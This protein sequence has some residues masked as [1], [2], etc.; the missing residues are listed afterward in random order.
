MPKMVS[1]RQRLLGGSIGY[2]CYTKGLRCIISFFV[3]DMGSS[4]LNRNNSLR[5]CCLNYKV[6]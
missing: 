6:C 2:A 5:H 3:P 1:L 4:H